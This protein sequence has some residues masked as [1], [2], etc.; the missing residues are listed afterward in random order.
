MMA[1]RPKFKC[2]ASRNHNLQEQIANAQ[3][4]TVMNVA[5]YYG[6]EWNGGMEE[7]VEANEEQIG[8]V[9]DVTN[10]YPFMLAAVGDRPGNCDL[11]TVFNLMKRRPDLAKLYSL[12]GGKKAIKRDECSVIW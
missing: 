2:A 1:K 12:G 10:L 11:S 5:S 7:V 4:Q 6:V 3:G 8:M 9:D